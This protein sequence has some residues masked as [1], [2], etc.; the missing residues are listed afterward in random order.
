MIQ[1]NDDILLIPSPMPNYK[2]KIL[3]SGRVISD[4]EYE[5]LTKITEAN[6]EAIAKD[7]ETEFALSP[8][9]NLLEAE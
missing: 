2:D 6:I 4:L 5:N 3:I 9:K 1:N 7:W 8:Y